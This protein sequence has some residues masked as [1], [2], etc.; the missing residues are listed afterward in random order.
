MSQFVVTRAAGPNW[1][2]GIG[3]FEQPDVNEHAAY[4]NA[5]AD[6]GVL[7]FA[8]P[9]GGSEQARIRVV[10]IADADS[11][12]EVRRLLSQDP[13]ERTDRVVTSS[14]ESWNV[15]VGRGRR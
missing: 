5:L 13:W 12:A 1:T 9:V 4:M 2:E 10:L 14:V 7:L 11:E 8:G 15:I 6:E 3:A